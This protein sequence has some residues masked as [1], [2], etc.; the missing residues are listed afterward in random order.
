M[1][2]NPAAEPETEAPIIYIPPEILEKILSNLTIKSLL[3]FRCVS[4]SWKSIISSPQFRAKLRG[5]RKKVIINDHPSHFEVRAAFSSPL[6]TIS[7]GGGRPVVSDATPLVYPFRVEAKLKAFCDELWCV[8]AK[9]SMYLW[10]PSTGTHKKLRDAPPVAP[11]RWRPWFKQ[12][13]IV[14]GLGYDAADDDYKLLK[15]W[16]LDHYGIEQETSLLYSLRNNSWREVESHLPR[17]FF[18]ESNGLLSN[19]ALHWMVIRRRVHHAA[20]SSAALIC[21]DF[22]TE[23][24]GAVEQPPYSPAVDLKSDVVDVAILRGMLCVFLNY[25]ARYRPDSAFVVW[26]MEDYGVA[27]SWMKL[28]EIGYESIPAIVSEFRRGAWFT[29]R[30]LYVYEDGEVVIWGS[31]GYKEWDMIRYKEREVVGH[32]RVVAPHGSKVIPNGGSVGTRVRGGF[33]YV[34]TLVSPTA[35]DTPPYHDH[36]HHT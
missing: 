15:I 13:Q 7:S 29:L 18:P 23:N 1:V 24:Y 5:S 2:D 16:R 17:G 12:P 3:R 30:P 34:E 25:K 32:C 33:V 19:R 21:F 4:T 8:V 10:N 35:W 26:A 20:E 11:P 22:R 6:S 9:K 31:S 36:L 14:Y 27:E 28:Y